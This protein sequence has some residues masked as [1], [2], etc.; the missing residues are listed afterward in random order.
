M[1]RLVALYRRPQDTAAFDKYYFEVHKPLAE[2][3]PGLTEYRCSKVFGGEKGKSPWY[4]MAEL[5]FK[6]KESL[7]EALFLP[8]LSPRAKTLKISPRAP[9]NSF[10]SMKSRLL[11]RA[12][13]PAAQADAAWVLR[14]DRGPVAVFTL[15]R[16]QALNALSSGVIA[17]L[18]KG[19][20]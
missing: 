20:E 1:V 12:E 19:L 15:N 16:P 11:S 9:A 14:E 2:K 18:L 6:D 8:N 5:C 7:K 3:I 17:Q 4:F 10:L 13:D